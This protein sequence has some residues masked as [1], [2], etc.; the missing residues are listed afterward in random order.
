VSPDPPDPPRASRIIVP[1]QEHAEPAD[2]ALPASGSRIVLPPGATTEPEESLPE[3]PRLRPLEIMPVREGDRDL[4]VVNDPLGV[5]PAPV[6]LRIEAFELMRLLDGTISL[7][8]LSAE[9]VRGSKD[10]R[11]A[12]FVRDFVGQLDRM[13]MLESPR[14]DAAYE[15]LRRSYHQLEIRQAALSGYSYPAEP[16]ELRRFL[17]AHFAAAR[18]L[19]VAAEPVKADGE[20]AV[21]EAGA[22][23]E[24][25]VVGETSAG[26]ET[27]VVAGANAAV[28]ISTTRPR[29]LM[30]PHLDPRRAGPVIARAIL[31]LGEPSN[32]PLRVVVIGTGHMLFG[33]LFALTRKHFE[34]PLGRVECDLRFVDAV[35]DKLGALAYDSELAHRT[36]HSIEFQAVYLKH[37]FGNRPLTIVPILCGGFHM[38]LDEK[39]TPREEPAFESLIAAVREVERSLGGETVYLAG[40][41]FS[42]I[43]PR[44][45]DP[46]PDERT[47]GEVEAKDR[48][49]IEAARRGDAEA[50]YEVIA[51]DEDAT[52]ICGWA[53]TYAMLR[54]AEPSEGQLLH[55][56][57]SSERDSTIVTI[58]AMRW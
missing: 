1:G 29:A 18:T 47:R 25:S 36:E 12:G 9:M 14:F 4:L 6:A 54:C 15:E 42:H 13:L 20:T 28:P 5:M 37:R 41:D 10:L 16:D 27:S 44:F 33:S 45:G 39:R 51:R 31:E 40:V 53:P 49:A 17:D 30:A 21:G 2:E 56:A 52:R 58:A 11:A 3:Y 34:T 32:Q 50:W 22:A 55:Y 46:A 35:A 24:P 38:L 23:A 8:D 26:A 48:E 57:Q 7:N 19:G 43:G